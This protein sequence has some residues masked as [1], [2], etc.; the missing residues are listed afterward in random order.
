MKIYLLDEVHFAADVNTHSNNGT[1]GTIH[2]LG[3][4]T[5]AKHSDCAPLVRI[6]VDGVSFSSSLRHDHCRRYVRWLLLHYY[7]LTR[8]D[9]IKFVIVR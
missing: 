4:T 8:F 9:R 6:S 5:A 7:L 3:V 1:D 2:S